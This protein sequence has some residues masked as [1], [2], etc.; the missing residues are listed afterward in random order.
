MFERFVNIGFPNGNLLHIPRARIS[1]RP[2]LSAC[3]VSFCSKTTSHKGPWSHAWHAKQGPPHTSSLV[4]S[5]CESFP[6]VP[7]SMA[8]C[9]N[10]AFPRPRKGG[11]GGGSAYVA[12]GCWQ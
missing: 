8:W 4:H 9:F 7:P 6:F 12:Q 2:G 11:G 10:A 3:K 1:V 5:N